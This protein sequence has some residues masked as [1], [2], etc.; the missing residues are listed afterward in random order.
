AEVRGRRGD[1]LAE[2][3]QVRDPR[4]GE[5]AGGRSRADRGTQGRDGDLAAE[6]RD[7]GGVREG[8]AAEGGSEAAPVR[9]G[10]RDR[11]AVRGGGRGIAERRRSGRAGV[12]RDAETHER[13]GGGE[14][15]RHGKPLW[16]IPAASSQ[17]PGCS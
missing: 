10:D 7:V 2:D 16:A 17:I 3:D 13:K 1:R 5:V 11:E 14:A 12:E 4:V 8:A 15:C 9:A 6:D